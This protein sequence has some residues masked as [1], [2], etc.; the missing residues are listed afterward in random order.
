[1]MWEF[2]IYP[3]SN[4]E[5]VVKYTKSRKTCEF[6]GGIILEIVLLEY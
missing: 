2:E 1:M 6:K 3:K 5:V 4:E